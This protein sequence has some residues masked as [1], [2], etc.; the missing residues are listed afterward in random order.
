MSKGVWPHRRFSKARTNM[1]FGASSRQIRELASALSVASMRGWKAVL[2]LF[3][4][5]AIVWRYYLNLF[6]E[7]IYFCSFPS[8]GSRSYTRVLGVRH[9]GRDC[10][11]NRQDSRF[12]RHRRP[13]CERHGCLSCIQS[14]GRWIC[15]LEI[16]K[17]KHLLS[18]ELPSMASGFRQS[19]PEWRRFLLGR[20]CV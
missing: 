9:S 7:N 13:K 3:E 6:Q 12:S 1:L 19:L 18:D 8:W 14:T 4:I 10:W 2:F 5:S 16:N 17:I 11:T 20:T 15:G